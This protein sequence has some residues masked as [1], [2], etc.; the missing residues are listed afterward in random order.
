M[1]I[2]TFYSFIEDGLEWE[3]ICKLNPDHY[4]TGLG[5]AEMWNRK[6]I[7]ENAVE[8]GNFKVIRYRPI[9][10][11]RN[12]VATLRYAANYNDVYNVC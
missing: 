10:L 1:E 8:Y 2:E 3:D 7:E 9:E 4:G 12:F 5:F 11:V 6:R